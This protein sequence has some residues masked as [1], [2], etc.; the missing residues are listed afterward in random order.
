MKSGEKPDPNVSST[1]DNLQQRSN[2][3]KQNV[4]MDKDNDETK[5]DIFD[6]IDG[7]QHATI[8]DVERQMTQKLG[9][10]ELTRIHIE[11]MMKQIAGQD[12]DSLDFWVTD[13]N[14]EQH[15]ESRRRSV[16]LPMFIAEA[17]IQIAD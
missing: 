4:F 8:G 15:A 6:S 5:T 12:P 2:K 9:C 3:Q 10:S 14:D 13:I 11:E 17:D 16:Q 1:F 7:Q